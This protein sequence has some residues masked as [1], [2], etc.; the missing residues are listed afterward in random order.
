[1]IVSVYLWCVINRTISKHSKNM[2]LMNNCIYSLKIRKFAR[3]TS[4]LQ[5]KKQEVCSARKYLFTKDFSMTDKTPS[6]ALSENKNI[7]ETI[8]N[9]LM[10]ILMLIFV[11]LYAAAFYG[12]FDPL[13]DNTMLLRFEPL[14]FLLIGY[15][16][17]RLPAR[18]SEK[19]LKD[20]ITRQMQ[21][22]DAV[23]YAKEKAQQE[24]ETLE[25]KIKNAKM[26]LEAIVPAANADKSNLVQIKSLK[27]A[28]GILDS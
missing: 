2:V 11:F 8:R 25:E 9:S 20:E 21:K 5:E 23:Q 13:K 26:A 1:M 24:R 6:T 28:I 10:V 22:A 18:Q 4:V 3:E 16:F 14:I 17:A 15:Y 27:A 7:T 12:K 19:M